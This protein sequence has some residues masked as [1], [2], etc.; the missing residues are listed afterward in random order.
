[1]GNKIWFN[2]KLLEEQEIRISPFDHGFLYGDGVFEGIR[3]YNGR[4]FKCWEHIDRLY[5]SAHTLMIN[6]PLTQKEMATACKEALKANN[7]RDAYIRLVVSRGP[8]DLGIDPRR[9]KGAPTICIIATALAL[10]P[11]ELYQKGLRVVTSNTRRIPVESFNPRVKSLNYL[12]NIMGKI[13]ANNYGVPEAIMLGE[14][15]VVCE[16]TADNIFTIKDGKVVT[17][18][19]WLPI[20][21]G[22]T[23][24]TVLDLCAKMG[25]P[26]AECPFT[27]HDVYNADE[28]FLTGT[29][30][31]LIPVIEVDGR[32]INDGTPGPIF[33]K[34]LDA[35]REY[36]NAN[37]EP[38]YE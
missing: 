20:L 23:R 2:G 38:I 26:A 10:Y 37:G 24:S 4:I 19:T 16:C 29:G 25:I 9:C 22:I 3:A 18:P 28:L 7:L 15:G 11:A 17:P 31:E 27:L 34:I 12:N 13:E 8:G 1:M 33:K 14:G 6:I 35:F 36:A 30:A 32:K 21:N 5:E